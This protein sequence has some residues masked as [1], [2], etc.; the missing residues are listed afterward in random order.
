[1]VTRMGFI[2]VFSMD[3]RMFFWLLLIA[4]LIS[5]NLNLLLLET[6][7]LED[8]VKQQPHLL[9]ELL[10]HSISQI[11]DPYVAS[12]VLLKRFFI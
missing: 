5:P 6:Y 8:G 10:N 12:S 2:K 1:M 3:I 11:Q 7:L 9:M 4:S